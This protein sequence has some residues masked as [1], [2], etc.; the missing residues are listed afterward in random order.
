MRPSDSSASS[1]VAALEEF[2]VNNGDLL[3][4]EGLIGRFNIFD[5]LRIAHVEIRHSNFLAWL[6]DPSESHGLG[7]MFL[8]AILMDLLG[9]SPPNLRPFSPIDLDCEELQGVDIRREWKHIDLLISSERPRFVVAIE[10]KIY[11]DEHDDQLGRYKDELCATFGDVPKIL[12]LLSRE[13][14]DPSKPDWVPYSYADVHR[15][16]E[17]VLHTYRDSIGAEVRM[18]I[19]QYLNLIGSRFMDNPQI[20]E[21]C[22]RIYRNHRQALDLIFDRAGVGESQLIP[23]L[24]RII[25]QNTDWRMLGSARARYLFF[26]PAD[27]PEILTKAGDAYLFP[28]KWMFE[29]WRGKLWFFI[30]VQ[31]YDAAA[32]ERIIQR[33]IQDP[34]EFE[35]RRRRPSQRYT[36]L[37]AHQCAH[38]NESDEPEAATLW[39][40]ILPELQKMRVRL[41]RVPEVLRPLLI[42]SDSTR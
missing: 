18:F 31:P 7:A 42:G 37:Y 15:V 38:W 35:L 39:P 23:D 26:V 22:R 1:A 8:R 6:I 11:S 17:R 33:L 21:L 12:V 41:S 30:E 29:A 2:V 9:R 5:A 4:L 16:L 28:V 20:D 25:A 10:N 19:E 13:G 3:R 14:V 36:R 34:S 27:W 32:R 24:E 40:R